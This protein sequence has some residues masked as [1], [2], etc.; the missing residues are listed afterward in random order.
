MTPVI[1]PSHASSQ[2]RSKSTL[3][4]QPREADV[5][6]EVLELRRLALALRRVLAERREVVGHGVVG[7]AELAQ[8]RAVDDQVGVAA[9]RRGEVRVRRAREARV[10]E[11]ARVVAR[12][13]ERAQHERRERLRARAPTARRTRRSATRS[14]RRASPPAAAS[15]ARAPA[16]SARRGR[17]AS[18]A[19]AR[20]TAGRAARAR[21]RAPRGA[22]PA[23]NAPTSSFARI[24]SS[25]TSMC[26][27]GSPSSHAS[28]TPPSPSKRKTD[29]RRLH[30]QRAAREALRAQRLRELVVQVER[31]E[32]RAAAPRGAAPAR[33][34]DARPSGSRSGRTA[35]RRAAGSRPSR[36]A[37]PDAGAASRGRRRARAAAS[38]RPCPGTYVENARR[39]APWSSGV[40][41]PTNHETSAMCTQARMP[42]SSRRNES[43]SSKSFAVSGIDRVGQQVAQVDP[44]RDLELRIGRV[45]GSNGCR[46]PR[47]TSSASST[48]SIAVGRPEPLLDVRPAAT[49]AHDREVAVPDVAD[50]L[51][52]EHDRHAGR[53]VRLTDDEPAAA[54]D[55][56]DET[57]RVGQTRRKRRIVRPE[58]IAPSARPIADQDQRD[59]GKASACTS[60]SPER[61]GRIDGSASALPITRKSTARIEP[62]SPQKQPL[63]HERS[64]HEPVRRAD[65]LHHLDLT[66]PREDRQPD[67]VRDQQ[68]R[69]DQQD[70]GRER[71][72]RL[73]HVR[74]LQ[75]SVRDLL[76]VVGPCRRPA[77]CAAY[78]RAREELVDVLGL[79]RRHLE[80]V[81]ERVRRQVLD[82]LRV[83]LL[84]LLRAPAPSRCT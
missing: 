64:A 67:R 9:D 36:T 26:A 13:L 61:C 8:Q 43:A 63:E 65:E 40:P 57:G 27:C 70:G 42:S 41:A 56:D 10:A 35:A 45:C 17:R 55:L 51:R 18:R 74:H 71:E 11:V 16:A 5:V 68:D 46:A 73:D 58:P 82:E 54:A 44:V 49:G 33:R 77:A 4:E 31:L 66:S 24:I 72:H 52:V 37:G 3:V 79:V 21:G 1:S 34:S 12:L 47:S 7:E 48:F 29:L 22:V 23:R 84:H 69:R 83:L 20:P 39:A 19:G 14:R 80:R 75:D 53:E 30:L 2:P 76:A 50:P 38:A 81:R 78:D 28:A 59:S 25:S 62:A 60:E 6:G 32:D 15:S